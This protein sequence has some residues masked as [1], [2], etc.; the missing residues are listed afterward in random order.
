M[1]RVSLELG[2]CWGIRIR[3]LGDDFRESVVGIVLMG[4]TGLRDYL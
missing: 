3:V 1:Q 2:V 4:S